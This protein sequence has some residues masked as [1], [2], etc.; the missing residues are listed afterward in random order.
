VRRQPVQNPRPGTKPPAPPA[1]PVDS[2]GF[3]AWALD[4]N[5]AAPTPQ[6]LDMAGEWLRELATAGFKVGQRGS[7]A[8]L[9]ARARHAGEVAER[10]RCA[11]VCETHTWSRPVEWWQES[12]KKFIASVSAR[13]CAAAIR[14]L[15]PDTER[16]PQPGREGGK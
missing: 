3:V 1:P 5:R 9:L 12:T 14:S 13:E 15:A 10:E 7:L 2:A 11:K 8:G 16:S 6:D 4:A